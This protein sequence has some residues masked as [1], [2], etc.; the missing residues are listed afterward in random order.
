MV[1]RRKRA[2]HDGAGGGKMDRELVRDRAMLDVG[3]AFRRQERG[4]DVAILTGFARG[5]R[6]ERSDRKAEVES[7]AIK[8]TRADAGARQ[9]EETV[10]LH[11]L[12]EFVHD[13]ENRVRSAIH[14]RAATDLHD[15]HPGQE[16]DRPPARDRT[17]EIGIEEG[18]ACE[19]RGDVLGRIGGFG[20]VGL[21]SR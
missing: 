11:Q 13:R 16:T 7:D 21:T 17:S 14:D 9:N 15:L 12:A 20:H 18:L 4:E 1:V 5:Q 19:R 6:R 8:V 3:D 10:L 2:A